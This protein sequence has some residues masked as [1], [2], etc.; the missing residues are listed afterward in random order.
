[1]NM[2]FIV[3][4]INTLV[5]PTYPLHSMTK[6]KPLLLILL[7]H[8]TFRKMPFDICNAHDTF[9]RCMFCI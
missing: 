1:M 3:F 7:A 2:L 8:Y 4:L 9:Q 6:G 5:T